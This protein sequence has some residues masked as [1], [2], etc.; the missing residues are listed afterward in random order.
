MVFPLLHGPWGEDGTL[1]GMLEMAGVRYVGAGVL[2]SAVSMDKDYMKVVLRG[3]RAAG[4]AVDHGDRRASGPRDP[5]R[6]AGARRRARLPAVREA[7]PRRVLHRHQQGP[8]RR[9]ARRRLA[10]AH[11]A[12]PQGAGR[13]RG[14]SAP[15][16]SSAACSGSLDG[17]PE[18]SVPGGDPGRRRRTSST[19]S[20]PSTSPTSRPSSTSRPTCPTTSS[21]SSASDGGA[22]LRGGRLRG[23][24]AGRLLRDARR[25]AGRQRDQ[26]D[27]RLHADVDVSRSCG[28]PPASTTPPWSTGCSSSRCAA[29]PA[30]ADGSRGGTLGALGREQRLDH[31]VR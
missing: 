30:C 5:R 10:E 1:Q 9:R 3:G 14:R 27:A 23:P 31:A 15:A 8:R 6:R 20:R 29:A 19:T 12:R 24:G 16:R 18:T 26:H 17:D 4:D 11:R 13:G 7:R 21:A 28:R 2:A 22:G 25:L